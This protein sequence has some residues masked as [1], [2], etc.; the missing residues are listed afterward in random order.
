[1]TL[2]APV[3]SEVGPCSFSRED[4]ASKKGVDF[5]H[6]GLDGGGEVFTERLADAV[7]GGQVVLSETTWS[8]IQD[9]IPGQPQASPITT[10]ATYPPSA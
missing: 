7:Y 5:A 10:A 8:A 9:H 2:G 4:P 1:M 3:S 6:M